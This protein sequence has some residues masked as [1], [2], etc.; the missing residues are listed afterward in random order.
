MKSS[1]LVK[2]AQEF[3]VPFVGAG[4]G[5]RSLRRRHSAR[6]RTD[7][8]LCP[9]E[10]HPRSGSGKRADGGSAGRGEP[11]YHARRAGQR[12]L[13][14]A[15]SVQP[16]RLHDRRQR[17]RE[18]RRTPHA[19][20]RRDHQSRS[21]TRVGA[22]RWHRGRDRRKGVRPAGLR[23]DRAAHRQRRHH[24]AGYQGHCPADAQAGDRQDRFSPSSNPAPTPAARW[25][26][27]RRAPS[28]RWRSRCS[29][30]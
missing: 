28:R 19:G 6:G 15:R 20:L 4:R 17:R 25:R 30:A 5:H 8:R 27:S 29:T 9:H 7:D 1:A 16:A 2:L 13:L 23:P 12:L 26:R 11:G 18:C 14:R 10:S 22:G 21:G 3:G 24:G